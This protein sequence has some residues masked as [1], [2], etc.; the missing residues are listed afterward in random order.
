MENSTF[1]SSSDTFGSSPSDE[2][3]LTRAT[4]SAHSAVNTMAEGADAAARKARPAIDQIAAMAHQAVDKA[5]ATAGPAADWLGEQGESLN[6]TQKKLMAN[7]C[8]YISAN[9][10][11]SVGIALL[12]GFLISRLTSK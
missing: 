5:A 3:A 9:P 8:S 2:G 1:G 11:T 4:G 6:A 12:A 10:M 7:T